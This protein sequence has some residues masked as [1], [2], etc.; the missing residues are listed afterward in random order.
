MQFGVLEVEKQ[1]EL[2]IGD[3]QVSKH[4]GKMGVGKRGRYF[5]IDNDQV[6]HDEVG[7]ESANELASIMDVKSFL[8]INY[9]SERSQF[10]D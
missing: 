9:V 5:R 10:N 2:E 4:L 7:N 6:V 3:I 8:L 1:C